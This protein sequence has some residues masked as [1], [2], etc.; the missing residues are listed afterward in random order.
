MQSCRLTKFAALD[1]LFCRY[2]RQLAARVTEFTQRAGDTIAHNVELRRQIDE[3]SSFVL[4]FAVLFLFSTVFLQSRREHVT[5]NTEVQ[6]VMLPLRQVATFS[7]PRTNCLPAALWGG[8]ATVSYMIDQHERIGKFVSKEQQ[9]AKELA[10]AAE[11]RLKSMRLQTQKDCKVRDPSSKARFK[12]AGCVS[13]L[14]ARLW[15]RGCRSW[16]RK[17]S[18]WRR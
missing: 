15:R 12:S 14:S 8:C 9:A 18:K 2:E 16:T 7:R 10:A 17:G 1:A 13:L 6:G 5:L 11:A 4:K 3:A